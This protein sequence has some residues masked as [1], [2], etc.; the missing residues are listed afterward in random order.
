MKNVTIN[1]IEIKVKC[2]E[3][4]SRLS[5]APFVEN[6]DYVK[7][8][9]NRYG[10]LDVIVMS[11]NSFIPNTDTLGKIKFVHPDYNS[12]EFM[13]EAGIE[14]TDENKREW[15]WENFYESNDFSN[16]VDYLYEEIIRFIEIEYPCLGNPSIEFELI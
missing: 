3:M 7:L 5:K 11:G 12:E 14:I 2:V 9:L 10:E 8:I 6:G 13:K 4:V 16:A 1:K 15:E